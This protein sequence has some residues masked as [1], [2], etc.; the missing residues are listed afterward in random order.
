MDV[1]SACTLDAH[2]RQDRLGWIRSEVLPHVR[3]ATALADGF[4]WECEAAGRATVE[5]W[6]ALERE[7]CGS[8]SW[9]V[10]LRRDGSLRL[11]VR[12][13]DPAVSSLAS[14]VPCDTGASRI[15]VL[16]TWTKAGGLGAVASFGVFCGVPMAVA[17]VFGGAVA[18]PLARLD[19]P[20]TWAGGTLAFAALIVWL[21][22]RRGRA[23]ATPAG[24]SPC[25]C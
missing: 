9:E 6:V 25:G 1:D 23:S 7:C 11:E 22:R 18:A 4:A 13:D 8:V 2:G 24:T 19:G 20:A 17:A 16:R 10:M 21:G 3:E 5:R 12:G 14:L 15:G